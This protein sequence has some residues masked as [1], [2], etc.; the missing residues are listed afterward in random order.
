MNYFIISTIVIIFYYRLDRLFILL[1]TGSS[2]V[3]RKAAAN[4][5]GQVVRL[6]PHELKPLLE[7]ISTYLRSS[8]WETRIAA[9]QAIEAVVKQ[10]PPWCPSGLPPVKLGVDCNIYI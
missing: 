6:H 4:Q 9:S 5:L 10:I 3:T 1:E 7:R 8:S 2:S